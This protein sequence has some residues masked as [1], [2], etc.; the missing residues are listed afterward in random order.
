MGRLLKERTPSCFKEEGQLARPIVTLAQLANPAHTSNLWFAPKAGNS[1]AL[2]VVVPAV[3]TRNKYLLICFPRK[4]LE[5]NIFVVYPEKKKK[6][7]Q[8]WTWENQ[9]TTF[10]M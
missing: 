6:K 7:K 3:D 4:N 9:S 10:Y 8:Q 5:N 1:N 2:V